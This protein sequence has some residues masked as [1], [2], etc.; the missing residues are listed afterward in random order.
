MHFSPFA[1]NETLFLNH[2]LETKTNNPR[3]SAICNL[4]SSFLYKT[5]LS[6][7]LN[8]W[9]LRCSWSIACRRC[10][11]Y[12]LIL[13]LTHGFSRLGKYNCKTGW[14]SLKFRN[15][16]RLILETL[17]F[18]F[19]TNAVHSKEK[20]TQA[21]VYTH[22]HSISYSYTCIYK[23]TYRHIACIYLYTWLCILIYKSMFM[24]CV[25]AW[26]CIY[27]YIFSYE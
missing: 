18:M 14:E 13:D 16:V 17:R 15:L 12:I 22:S 2:V 19:V 21:R 4:P 23:H 7:Q 9:S 20:G 5:H 24:I 10:S 11:N 3:L 6:W 8:C 1:T 25:H 26:L 27:I